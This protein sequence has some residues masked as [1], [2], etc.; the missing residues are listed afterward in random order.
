MR[1]SSSLLVILLL[2]S[3]A[4]ALMTDSMLITQPIPV[5]ESEWSR[6]NLNASWA[7]SLDAKHADDEFANQKTQSSVGLKFNFGYDLTSFLNMQVNP[8]VTS[9][10]GYIQAADSASA[11]KA[12][13]IDINEASANLHDKEWVQLSLGALNQSEQF[14]SLLIDSDLAFPALRL[15]VNVG[16]KAKSYA[17]LYA[18]AAVPTSSS[19]T[20]NSKDFEKTPSFTAAGLRGKLNSQGWTLKGRASYFE[21]RDLPTTVAT[22]STVLG[23]TPLNTPQSASNE[24]L[25][26]YRGVEGGLSTRLDVNRNLGFEVEGSAVQNQAAPSGLNQAYSAKA[27]MD[28]WT[29][30]LKW[31]PSFEYF[32]LQ[33]DSVVAYYNSDAYQTNRV[34][35]L[36]GIALQ[37]HKMF[38]VEFKGGERDV[39][40]E[41]ATQSRERFFSLTLE[42]LNALL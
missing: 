12:S 4:H 42:T 9:R 22:D 6:K 33:P 21:Y 24:F 37:Y 11:P 17:G 1:L 34:G 8:R 7:V 35:Y 31:T 39:A 23:N 10:N 40:F 20:T 38:K 36:A 32:D 27:K 26:E 25:Y 16:E 18:E 14:S 28:L 19:L 30:Q 3:Q 2:G 41:T 29:R 13:S 5:G 15:A